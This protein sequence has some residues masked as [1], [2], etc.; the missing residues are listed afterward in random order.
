MLAPT[1]SITIWITM[2][3][4][5]ALGAASGFGENFGRSSGKL[6]RTAMAM[7]PM[8]KIYMAR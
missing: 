8:K 2:T 6:P 7:M 4:E 1:S 5:I 3:I